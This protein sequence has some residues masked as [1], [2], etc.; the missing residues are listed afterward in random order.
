MTVVLPARE[1]IEH[2]HHHKQK[3]DRQRQPITPRVN[4]R[5]QEDEQHLRQ[6]A[7]R[8]MPMLHG[9]H[10]AGRRIRFHDV[11]LLSCRIVPPRRSGTAD[12]VSHQPAL[13][14]IQ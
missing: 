3:N 14:Y 6:Q 11:V 13:S 12:H 7:E 4:T 8:N 10:H 5:G 2:R 9:S 1:Q